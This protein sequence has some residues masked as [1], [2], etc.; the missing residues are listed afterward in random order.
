[1]VKTTDFERAFDEAGKNIIINLMVDGA[2]HSVLIYDYQ[3]DYLTGKFLNIDFYEVRMDKKINASVPIEFIGEAP[4][5]KEKDA[6]LVKTM[7]EVQVEALPQNLPSKLVADLGVLMEIGQSL[8]IKDIK[9]KG[10]FEILVDSETVIATA[11][12]MMPEED[13]KPAVAVG[14]VIAETDLKKTERELRKKEVENLN[15]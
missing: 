1:M 12:E 14:E 5:V 2:F 13:I 7:N 15:L 11:S 10:D 4:A 3:N 6:I 9:T 8:F